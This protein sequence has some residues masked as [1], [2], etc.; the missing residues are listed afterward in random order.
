MTDIKSIKSISWWRLGRKLRA[1]RDVETA[2]RDF[3]RGLERTIAQLGQRQGGDAESDGA[4]HAR[5]LGLT[6]DH[7]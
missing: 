6:A 4:G 2:M 1:A 3:G 5:A 7:P